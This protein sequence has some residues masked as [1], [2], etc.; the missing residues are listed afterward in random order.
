[1]KLTQIDKSSLQDLLS[2]LEKSTEP[3]K[4]EIDCSGGN[5]ATAIWFVKNMKAKKLEERLSIHVIRAESAAAY[6]VLNLNCLR[7]IGKEGVITIHGGRIEGELNELFLSGTWKYMTDFFR[8]TLILLKKIAPRERL[9]I[10]YAKNHI[11]LT[12][13]EIEKTG[14]QF[15]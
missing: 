12:R 9:D 1:M 7:T 4:L 11:T 13:E 2:A 14:I 10:F 8:D 3:I 6:I 5:V 15:I